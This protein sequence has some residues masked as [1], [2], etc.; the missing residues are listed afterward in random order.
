MRTVRA[1]LRPRKSGLDDSNAPH[2][3]V[4]ERRKTLQNA[5]ET[6][7]SRT[8][9]FDRA[10]RLRPRSERPT[11]RPASASRERITVQ[12]APGKLVGPILSPFDPPD[13]LLPSAIQKRTL[14]KMQSWTSLRTRYLLHDL[15]E[16]RQFRRI[17]DSRIGNVLSSSLWC[18][19]RPTFRALPSHQKVFTPMQRQISNGCHGLR[20]RAGRLEYVCADGTRVRLARRPETG[21]LGPA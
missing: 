5:P 11:R 21:I 9:T 18:G 2:R 14:S 13:V 15:R 16:P 12:T 4:T 17:T 10:T 8:Q 7:R 6:A 1:R 20:E 3:S 19:A